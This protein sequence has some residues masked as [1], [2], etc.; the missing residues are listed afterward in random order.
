MTDPVQAPTP[1]APVV[2]QQ[3]FQVPPMGEPARVPNGN[4]VVAPGQTPGW[5]PQGQQPPAQPGA[6]PA[7]PDMTSVVAMLQAALAGKPVE[8]PVAPGN[9]DPASVRPSWMQSSANEFDVSSIDDPIIRSMA[10]VM[11]TVGKDLDLDRVLGKA[12]AY[13]DISLIDE[14]YLRDSA[15]AN[16]PQLAEIARGIVQAVEAKSSAVT[17]AVYAEVGG[18]AEWNSAVAAF[19]QSAPAELR[20][21]I[22]QMLDSTNEQF[23]K[24][25]AKIVAEFGKSSG[26]IPQTG[27]PLLNT[28]AAGMAGQGLSK[29]EFQAELRK[30]TPDTPGY[31]EAREA[32]F[33][34]RSLG[35]RAGK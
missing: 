10:T 25:G 18:E 13:G 30:L 19:N 5:M 24:A 15:G 23:I 7:Q 35:K 11:Q 22:A 28:A 27:A 1:V 32:L 20:M 33:V 34:R 16:A 2:P 12:L 6:Q 4:P 31:E 21:T 9:V 29:V 14:A 26:M 3:S 8:P 17:A